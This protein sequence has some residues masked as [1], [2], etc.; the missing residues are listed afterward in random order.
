MYGQANGRIFLLGEGDARTYVCM[1]I[2]KFLF[3]AA[4]HKGEEM[5][6]VDEDKEEVGKAEVMKTRWR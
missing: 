6:V 5:G 2:L 4:A 3:R 1:D